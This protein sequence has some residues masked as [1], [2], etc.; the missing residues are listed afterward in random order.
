MPGYGKDA[1]DD[2]RHDRSREVYAEAFAD[3][4]GTLSEQHLEFSPS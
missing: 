3:C 4:A 2:A 1:D